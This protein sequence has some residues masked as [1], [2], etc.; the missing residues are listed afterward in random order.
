MGKHYLD[1]IDISFDKFI[2]D[3]LVN[4]DALGTVSLSVGEEICNLPPL[5]SN[6]DPS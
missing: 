5:H 3:G 6:S 4:I 2:V 1:K